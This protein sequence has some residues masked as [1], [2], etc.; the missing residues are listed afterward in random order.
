MLAVSADAY[1]RLVSIFLLCQTWLPTSNVLVS[2]TNMFNEVWSQIC[3]FFHDVF[4][5]MYNIFRGPFKRHHSS[6]RSWKAERLPSMA[7]VWHFDI[8]IPTSLLRQGGLLAQEAPRPEAPR[9]QAEYIACKMGGWETFLVKGR[10]KFGEVMLVSGFQGLGI[11]LLFWGF[12]PCLPVL[13][14]RMTGTFNVVTTFEGDDFKLHF[15]CLGKHMSLIMFDPMWTNE[16]WA[17]NASRVSEDAAVDRESKNRNPPSKL[18]RL[19][20]PWS[21][22]FARDIHSELL[23]DAPCSVFNDGRLPKLAPRGLVMRDPLLLTSHHPK[24]EYWKLL[25]TAWRMTVHMSRGH[26][27]WWQLHCFDNFVFS[28]TLSGLTC[29][30]KTTKMILPW[31]SWLWDTYLNLLK[32][33]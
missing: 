33:W 12:F 26:Q 28:N 23:T 8:D 15:P 27:F 6:W 13:P 9:R 19:A 2:G 14:P 16:L 11:L 10:A 24:M 3:L 30:S 20:Q 32:N 31:N 7:L 5:F 1:S 4:L 17:F 29:K 21:S 18:F 25:E 22:Y